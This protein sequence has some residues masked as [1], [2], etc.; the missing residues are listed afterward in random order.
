M[1][2]GGWKSQMKRQRGV[3]GDDC[4]RVWVKCGSNH[5]YFCHFANLTSL[6]PEPLTSETSS[7]WVGQLWCWEWRLLEKESLGSQGML[8]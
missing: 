3:V 2:G 1:D 5:Y 6:P 7:S 4:A 8:T